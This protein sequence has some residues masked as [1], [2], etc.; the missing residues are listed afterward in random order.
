M[1]ITAIVAFLVTMLTTVL[2]LIPSWTWP[3]WMDGTS[4]SCPADTLGCGAAAVGD[5]VAP[6]HNWLPIPAMVTGLGLIG[7]ALVAAGGVRLTRVAISMMTGG[8]GSA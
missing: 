6:F 4:G 5:Y 2:D 1:I 3:A 8:G 7:I